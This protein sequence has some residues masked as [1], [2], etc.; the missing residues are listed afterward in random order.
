MSYLGQLLL[1]SIPCV[2]TG[3]FALLAIVVQG[4]RIRDDVGK[5]VGTPNGQGN[6]VQM[7]ERALQHQGKQDDRM[8]RVLTRLGRI[9]AGQKQQDERLAALEGESA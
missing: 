1:V 4:R 7:L 8:E 2:I 6:V 9:E 5:R 3:L